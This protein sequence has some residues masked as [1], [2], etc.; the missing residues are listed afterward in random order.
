MKEVDCWNCRFRKHKRQ[1]VCII[2]E[3][4]GLRTNAKSNCDRYKRL[5]WK[6][7]IKA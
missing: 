5:W 3:R 4:G 6:F 2:P 7:W 1:G